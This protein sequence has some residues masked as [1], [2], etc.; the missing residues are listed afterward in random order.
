MPTP[1]K[2]SKLRILEGD[3][4]QDRHGC[5]ADL[6]YDDTGPEQLSGLGAHGQWLYETTVRNTPKQILNAVD[7]AVIFS[8]CRWWDR[9]R[10]FDEEVDKDP[11]QANFNAAK[12]SFDRYL[13]CAK[14]IGCTPQSRTKIDL[15]EPVE[16]DR[17]E[18]LRREYLT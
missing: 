14:E 7:S 6:A 10:L 11:S 5:R 13:Q 8:M 17:N 16:D 18:A 4:R 2:P 15:S 3:F 9:F 1:R 12:F